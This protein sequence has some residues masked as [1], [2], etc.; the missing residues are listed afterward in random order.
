MT[1]KSGNDSEKHCSR[2]PFAYFPAFSSFLKYELFLLKYEVCLLMFSLV[3]FHSC[4]T[5]WQQCELRF[6]FSLASVLLYQMLRISKRSKDLEC[7]NAKQLILHS[8]QKLSCLKS[9]VSDFSTVSLPINQEQSTAL[10]RQIKFWY[11]CSI[12]QNQALHSCLSFVPLTFLQHTCLLNAELEH[13]RPNI[14][15]DQSK[16]NNVLFKESSILCQT[17]A[18]FCFSLNQDKFSSV[19]S[20]KEAILLN[21]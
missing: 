6:S 19:S 16:S 7:K 2:W 4:R 21:N 5:I 11:E 18:S 3:L 10:L 12:R 9:G 17:E 15:F 8:H 1:L 13:S 14:V 20:F